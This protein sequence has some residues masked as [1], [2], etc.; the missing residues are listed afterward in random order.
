MSE[1]TLH[2]W[3]D[4]ILPFVAKPSHRADVVPLYARAILMQQFARPPQA[5]TNWRRVN[6]AIAE[7]WS[8][9]AVAWIKERAWKR[10]AQLARELS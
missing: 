6:E 5:E 3:A 9:A 10:A 2:D 1:H 4:D 7:R 8:W